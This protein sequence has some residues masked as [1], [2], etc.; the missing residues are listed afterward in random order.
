MG[1]T[2]WGIVF[3]LGIVTAIT[4][5]IVVVAWQI[6][7][8]GKAATVA[9]KEL[10]RDTAYRTLAEEATAAQRAL[11]DE[12][13]KIAREMAEIRERMISVERMLKEVG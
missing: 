4:I 6:L 10:A 9:D 3:V 5:V 8:I 11:A 7:G 12:Q 1:D 2:G 13:R